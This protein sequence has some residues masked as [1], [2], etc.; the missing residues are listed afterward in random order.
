MKKMWQL[1]VFCAGWVAGGACA[2]VPEGMAAFQDGRCSKAV[3]Q[4]RGPAQGGHVE[5]Q[6]VLGDIYV[7][8]K[9]CRDVERSD[10]EA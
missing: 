5:A 3:A 2:G 4:L 8:E 1:A 10:T 7:G 9:G 6:K